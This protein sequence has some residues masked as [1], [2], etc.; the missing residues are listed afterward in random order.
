MSH[1]NKGEMGVRKQIEV[2]E[3]LRKVLGQ[4]QDKALASGMGVASPDVSRAEV[5]QDYLSNETAKPSAARE[6]L[7]LPGRKRRV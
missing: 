5:P 2:K 3:I 1:Q 6:H 4:G 7:R